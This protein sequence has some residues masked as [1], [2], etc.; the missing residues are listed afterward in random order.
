M[1]V[2]KKL[3]FNGLAFRVL[4][5]FVL[6]F[7]CLSQTAAALPDDQKAL[8]NNNILY[9]DIES[10]ALEAGDSSSLDVSGD[11]SVYQ[12]GLQPPY[13]LEQWAIHTLKAIALKANKSESDAVTKEHVI[14]LVAF[15][16]GEGGDINNTSSIFNPLNTGLNAPE[17]INGS[18]AVDGTQ[19]FKSFDAGVEAT[20]RTMVGSNQDR[21]AKVLVKP[22]S[23]ASDFM[24][25]LTYYKRYSG[26]KFWA[27]ASIPDPAGYYRGRMSLVNTVR[28]NYADNASF[29]IGTS[30]LEQPAGKR[31]KSKLKF[32]GSSNV[33]TSDDSPTANP[34]CSCAVAGNE[35]SGALVGSDNQE[36]AFNFFVSDKGASAI[37]AAGIVGNLMVESGEKIDP[38]AASGSH[39]GIAQWDNAGRWPNLVRYAEGKGKS[40]RSFMTQLEFLWQ[41]GDLVKNYQA[42]NPGSPE[43]AAEEFDRIFERSGGQALDKRKRFAKQVFDKY[44]DSAQPGS[45][46]AENI[47]PSG[48]A[49]GDAFILDGNAWPVGLGKSEVAAMKPFP[50]TS[51][52]HHDGTAAFDLAHKDTFGGSQDDSKTVGK[53]VYAIADGK[54]QSSKIYRGIAGCYAIQFKASD[55]YVYWYGHIRKPVEATGNIKAGDKIAE[56]GERKCTGN[57]SAPHLHIDR[58]SPKGAPGGSVNS[59]DEGILRVMNKLYEKLP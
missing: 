7:F 39:S 11:S 17:L 32:D 36:Q 27:A 51:N 34:E 42:T 15:A 9:Y 24:T 28:S 56:I 4:S 25:A 38:L 16:L 45:A 10:C 59:R 2:C 30:E 33:A 20:A 37:E 40:P 18:N 46:V 12:S 29:I 21:L 55:G 50:C 26:N 5:L 44:G 48:G 31:D 19:A 14:A 43:K 8:F 49:N 13:I 52:C 57:G 22:D 47:C 1:N 58:G 35:E 6:T 3:E 23:T 54:I 53:A 41:E